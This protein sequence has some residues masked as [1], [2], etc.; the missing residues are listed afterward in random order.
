[1]EKEIFIKIVIII[2]WIIISL[3][4]FVLLKKTVVFLSK[5]N[6]K[7]KRISLNRKKYENFVE[8]KKKYTIK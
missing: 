7:R 3:I 8:D 5:W 4:L 6:K 2:S 1:M